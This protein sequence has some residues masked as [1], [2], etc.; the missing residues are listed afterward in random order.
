MVHRLK[1]QG[2]GYLTRLMGALMASVARQERLDE[3]CQVVV[4]VPLHW[5][6]RLSRGYDQAALLAGVVAR[7]L[8]LPLAAGVV[9]RRRPTPPQTGL[10]RADRVRNV[11]DSFA[12]TRAKAVWER[13]VL[14]VDDVLTTGATADACAGALE[15][16]GVKR[17]FVLTFA[18]AGKPLAAGVA[19]A[20]RGEDV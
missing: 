12:A 19:W 16:A 7:R 14:L 3:L 18:R 9:V 15:E 11:A 10:S 2:Q 4:A 20:R 5:R 1:Y 6:R 8:Q 17:V 13:T